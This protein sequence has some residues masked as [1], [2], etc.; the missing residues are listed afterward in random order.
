MNTTRLLPKA[1]TVWGVSSLLALA[2][3]IANAQLSFDDKVMETFMASNFFVGVLVGAEVGTDE[4]AVLQF[5]S[6]IGSNYPGYYAYDMVTF[7]PFAGQALRIGGDGNLDSSTL[8]GFDSIHYAWGA[9]DEFGHIEGSIQWDVDP[10]CKYTLY[11]GATKKY[12]LDGT[13]TVQ[14]DGSDKFSGTLTD[15]STGKSAPAKGD[16]FKDSLGRWRIDG[17]VPPS[18]A[19]LNGIQVHSEGSSSTF[20]QT[21][22][23]VPEPTTIGL[24]SLGLLALARRRR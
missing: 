20:T 9:G 19:S 22:H 12:T 10:L 8:L 3:A 23:A 21:I 14:D 4:H 16:S 7:Q 6:S 11:K 2:P 24:L 17:Y 13:L 18:L 5:V 1:H 15:E